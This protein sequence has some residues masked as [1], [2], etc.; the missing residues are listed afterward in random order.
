MVKKHTFNVRLDDE[1]RQR[2]TR[3]AAELGLDETEAMRFAL[4][5]T[6]DRVVEQAMLRSAD[7]KRLA[8]K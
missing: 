1:G 8:K 4:K 6:Y 7:D 5:Q 3:L 2:L